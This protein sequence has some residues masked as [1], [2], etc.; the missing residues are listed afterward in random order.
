[1]T[2]KNK[3]HNNYGKSRLT[4]LKTSLEIVYTRTRTHIDAS[5]FP[6]REMFNRVA[7]YKLYS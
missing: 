3:G 6:P 4:G 7:Q 5:D 1:M 2:E